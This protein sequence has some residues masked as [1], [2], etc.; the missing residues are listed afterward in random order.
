MDTPTVKF[1]LGSSMSLILVG[2]IAFGLNCENILDLWLK[3]RKP[4][5]PKLVTSIQLLVG[6]LM[7]MGMQASIFARTFYPEDA[8]FVDAASAS[9]EKASSQDKVAYVFLGLTLAATL[10]AL[11]SVGVVWI[12]MAN[13]IFVRA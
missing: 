11:V 12:V 7:M 3:L 9:V 10:Q 4:G 1:W 5:D 6:A 8:T 2:M 13:A